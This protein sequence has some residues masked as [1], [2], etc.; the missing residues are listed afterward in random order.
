MKLD[1]TKYEVTL[2]LREPL[3][4]TVPKDP[5]VYASYVASKAAL[6]DDQLAEELATVGKV[7]EKGWTGF[8]KLPDGMPII[9]D[10]AIKGYFKEA[11]S[12]LRRNPRSESA[13]LTAHKKIVDGLVFVTPR[14]IPIKLNG[15]LGVLERPLRAQTAQGERIAL[16]RSDTAPAGSTITFTLVVYDPKVDRAILTEW[17]DYGVL[18]GLGQWRKG[19]YGSF[20][21][22]LNKIE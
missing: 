3:L 4:G 5:D 18:H 6:T 1:C 19:G 21:Y 12:M 16:S 20:T 11:C 2:T 9:Y 22:T 13:K 7:E 10:Y 15:D 17:L 8:H 14:Q